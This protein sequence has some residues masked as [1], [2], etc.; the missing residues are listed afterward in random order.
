M[1]KTNFEIPLSPMRFKRCG[2]CGCAEHKGANNSG[3]ST[4]CSKYDHQKIMNAKAI[5]ELHDENLRLKQSN[6]ELLSALQSLVATISNQDLT[7]NRP[8]QDVQGMLAKHRALIHRQLW[9][10]TDAIVERNEASPDEVCPHC[11]GT[12]IRYLCAGSTNYVERACLHCVNGR[13]PVK[14]NIVPA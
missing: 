1:T 12:G 9:K 5:T 11:K 10:E 14:L 7:I 13:R 8:G 6:G 4:A 3:H 2:E